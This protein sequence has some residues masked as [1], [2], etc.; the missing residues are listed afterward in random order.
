MPMVYLLALLLQAQLVF[1][2][3]PSVLSLN[4]AKNLTVYVDSDAAESVLLFFGNG[5]LKEYVNITVSVTLF[6]EERVLKKLTTPTCNG[7][8]CQNIPVSTIQCEVAAAVQDADSVIRAYPPITVIFTASNGRILS[9]NG[10]NFTITLVDRRSKDNINTSVKY[11]L[12]YL[13]LAYLH[14]CSK[15]SVIM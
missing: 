2:D 13:W 10:G 11:T 4:Y 12:K 3:T 6:G 5:D 9:P 15:P 14:A 7:R 1:S 8:P